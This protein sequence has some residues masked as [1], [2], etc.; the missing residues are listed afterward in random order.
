MTEFI[1]KSFI[2]WRIL[3]T[4][5]ALVGITFVPLRGADLLGGGYKNYSASPLFWSWANFDGEHYMSIAK[6]G[7]RSLEHA[8]FPGYPLL[9]RYLAQPFG[10]TQENILTVGLIVSNLANLAALF[11]FWKL[12]RLDYSPKV[13]KLSLLL[14]LLF[15]T[16][17]FFGA[18][19]TE[20]LFLLLALSSFYLARKSKWLAAGILGAAASFT[21]VFGVL[22]LPALFLEYR[23][24]KT[25][26]GKRKTEAK[27][28]LLLVPLG[29][30][31]YM[32][33]LQKTVGD[34]IAFYSLQPIIGE[35][36]QT[37]IVLLPQVFWRYVKMLV[38]VTK[39]DPIYFTITIEALSGV[40]GLL[41]LIW[42]YLKK[43]R[44]SYLVFAAGIYLGPSITGSFT[45]LPRYWLSIFPFFL[46]MA[47]FL[48]KRDRWQR[49]LVYTVLVLL[50]LVE[51]VLFVRGYWV[52]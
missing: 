20:S 16:S 17:F 29:I 4:V 1:L 47:L 37:E 11:I 49:V 22:V 48:S 21:R 31:S 39:T 25:E 14:L 23:D 10:P 40:L 46:M 8:F 12:I 7:Y 9:L 2:G 34:P 38:T 41:L 44:L 28:G 18:L 27:I 30:L 24:Q 45:S 6:E 43:V 13:A 42:G 15:P 35:Q 33:F 5:F 32:Y 36:H 52:A 19:Y 26:N 3:I 50:L 51:T